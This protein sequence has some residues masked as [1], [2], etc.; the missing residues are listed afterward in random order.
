VDDDTIQLTFGDYLT[1]DA[2]GRPNYLF[3]L[4]NSGRRDAGPNWQRVCDAFLISY[5]MRQSVVDR[6]LF[7]ESD[8]DD[9]RHAGPHTTQLTCVG[10]IKV[11]ANLMVDYPMHGGRKLY[12][13]PMPEDA[14]RKLRST[15]PDTDQ[16]VSPTA[17]TT[18]WTDSQILPDGT[19]C[20]RLRKDSRWLASRYA[21]M[22]SGEAM[23]ITNTQKTAADDNRGDPFTKPEAGALFTNTVACFSV[24]TTRSSSVQTTKRRGRSASFCPPPTDPAP[25]SWPA[26]RRRAKS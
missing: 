14:L 8:G 26:R 19:H 20:E 11:I 2:R 5:G 21:T 15:S 10:V 24:W 4:G 1:H 7:I 22:R 12:D 3:M 13:P 25:G 17:P 6:R 16:G 23:G 18:L 9:S